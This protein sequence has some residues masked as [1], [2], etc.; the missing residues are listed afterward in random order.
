[1]LA[2]DKYIFRITHID[3]ISHILEFGITHKNSSN[4]NPNYRPIG[5]STLINKRATFELDNGRYLGDY[6]PFYFGQRSPMQF[7]IE[8]GHNGVNTVKANEILYCVSSINKVLESQ[9]PF[10]YTDGHATDRLTKFYSSSEVLEINKHVDF[11]AVK[12]KNWADWANPEDLDLK[13]RKEAELLLGADLDC[14]LIVGFVVRYDFVKAELI[15]KYK[16]EE[17]QIAVRSNFYY[18]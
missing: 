9:I 5:D 4:S 1:M 2:D 3:N 15:E 8:R 17:K 10:I 11:D 14:N 12:A 6:I 18:D 13:R 7:V 16:L